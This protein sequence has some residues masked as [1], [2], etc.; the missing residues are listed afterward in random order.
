M[1]DLEKYK[2]IISHK[3]RQ[4]RKS[5]GLTQEEFCDKIDIEIPTFSNIENGKSLPSTSTLIKIKKTFKIEPNE[6]W[7]FIDWNDTGKSQLDIEIQEYSATL[8][9]EMKIHVLE[10]LK[11]LK[12]NS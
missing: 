10:I 9:N 11:N 12:E 5:Q 7:D 3:I 8:S 6:F 4:L 2:Q 1:D